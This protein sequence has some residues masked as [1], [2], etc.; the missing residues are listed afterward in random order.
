MPGPTAPLSC[1]TPGSLF[2]PGFLSSCGSFSLGGLLSFL[3]FLSR[4]GE[5]SP[6]F[7]LFAG[8][9]RKPAS[10]LS[11]PPCS[12]R[13]SE[14][15]PP[16]RLCLKSGSSPLPARHPAATNPPTALSR[17]AP[18]SPQIT[19]PFGSPAFHVLQPTS[20]KRTRAAPRSA[21]PSSFL[22]AAA[23]PGFSAPA[24]RR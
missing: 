23:R 18:S 5:F 1:G 11:T 13:P 21:R 8:L 9:L 19:P 12:R 20:C 6:G 22:I 4:E 17:P 3:A 7:S 14:F 24:L 16:I 10:G 2:F 15:P